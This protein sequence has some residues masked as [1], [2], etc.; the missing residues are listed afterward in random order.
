MRKKSMIL[1]VCAALVLV[2][3]VAAVLIVNHNRAVAAEA[4][5][6]RIYNETYLVMDGVEYLRSSTALDLSGKQITELEKLQELKA[7]Q[8]LNLRDTG[9]T[10][11]Q[12]ELLHAAL[13]DCE[14]LWS[15]PFQGGYRDCTTRELVLE[16]LCEAD[17]PALSYF[18]ALTSVNADLC[19]DY[20]AIFA[21]MAQYPEL[22]VAYTVPIG[23]VNVAHT[24]EELTV[25]D[26]DTAELLQ[27]IPLL[28]NLKLVTLEGSLPSMEA[29]AALKNALPDVTFL[30]SFT[31]CGVQTD[32]RAA[33]LDLSN[34]KMADT[35]ELEAALP[36]FYNLEKVDMISCGLS[37]ADMESLNLRHPETS[38]VWTVRVSGVQV[39]T[40]IKYFMFW[41]LKQKKVG[42]LTNLRYCTEV[43]VLDFGHFGIR[44][45]SF[46][47]Y[48]PK[49]RFLL[50]LE[51][52]IS[53]LSVIGNCTSLEFLELSTSP[54]VDF[55]PLTNLTNLKALNLSHTPCYGDNKYGAFG[56]LTPLFQMTWLERLWLANSRIGDDGRAVMYDALPTTEMIFF[57]K[58]ATDRGWRFAP[59]YYEM[60]DILGMYYQV[61]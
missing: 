29:L 61:S 34:I 44:D 47:E 27:Q 8:T 54:V 24:T 13:P 51:T 12:Y 41:K 18:P 40:D 21:L 60:R 26:P 5:R 33:F 6:L 38:F 48:M 19:R 14:I 49:L 9:I 35:A 10:A 17:L 55:W 39:R 50:L 20:D 43:E 16:T 32:S 57:S 7:L 45:V 23:G 25:T 53:D 30:W 11:Q 59:A 37:N 42:D 28:P 31:V 22:S 15:V 46:I 3:G 52:Y 1:I 2:C 58:S 36:C 56:D 4:E